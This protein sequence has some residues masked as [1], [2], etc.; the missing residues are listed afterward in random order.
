[1]SAREFELYLANLYGIAGL[2]CD[3]MRMLIEF[4][5]TFNQADLEA[6]RLLFANQ[7]FNSERGQKW[8]PN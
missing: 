5:A 3:V 7:T 2:R 1:M 8:L 4:D 6:N